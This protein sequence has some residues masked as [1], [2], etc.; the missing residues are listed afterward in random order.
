MDRL[1]FVDIGRFG[2]L[3]LA[4][5]PSETPIAA[6]RCSSSSRRVS[7]TSSVSYAPCLGVRGCILTLSIEEVV[8]RAPFRVFA[9]GMSCGGETCFGDFVAEITFPLRCLELIEVLGID[10][11]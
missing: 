7:S 2:R 3:A 9:L 8:P 1:S 5:P 10:G 4:E 11:Y 6:W